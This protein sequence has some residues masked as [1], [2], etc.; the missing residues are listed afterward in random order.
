MKKNNLFVVLAAALTAVTVFYAC[1]KVENELQPQAPQEPGAAPAYTLTVEAVKGEA[2]KALTD[3][4]TTLTSSWAA[5]DNVD[6]YDA[7]GAKLGTLSAAVSSTSTTTLSGNLTTAPAVGDVLTL[8]FKTNNYTNQKGTLEY[9][10]ANCDYATAEVTVT[11]VTG[12]AIQTTP[13]NFVSQQAIVKFTLRDSGDTADLNVGELLVNDG[14]T[15]YTVTP[16]PPATPSVLYVALESFSEKTV[17]LSAHA[18]SVYYDRKSENVTFE[19]GKYYRVKAL[20][21]PR[22]LKS[23]SISGLDPAPS[24]YYGGALQ[25]EAR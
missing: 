7:N 19:N 4:G 22:V 1:N 5:G 17:T 14:T 24:Y 12:N 6:V 20:M 13:A 18:G 8:K 25:I 11:A 10:A 23:I 21:T 9:I 15:T 16:D 3:A 2:T